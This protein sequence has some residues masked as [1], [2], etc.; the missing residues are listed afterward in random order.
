MYKKST[1]RVRGISSSRGQITVFMILGLLILF[2]F[3]FVFSLS[4]GIKKSQ[5]QDIQEKTLTKSFKKEALRI[6][7][8]DCLIDE[9]ETGLVII[10]KQGRLWSDQPGG[11]R[12][13]EEGLS[14]I[15]AGNDRVFYGIIRDPYLEY[16]NAYPCSNESSPDEFCQYSYPDTKV[17]FGSLELRSSTIQSDLRRYLLNRTVWCVSEFTRNNI[18]SSAVL[19][20]QEINLD[21]G[22]HDHGIDVKVNYP[23]KLSLGNEEFFHLSQFDFFYPTRFKALLDTAVSYPLRIDW[24]YVDFSYNKST[25]E[26]TSFA[27]GNEVDIQNGNCSPFKNYFF[28]QQALFSEQY[29]SLGVEMIRQPLPN[30]DDVFIFKSPSVLNSPELYTYQFARQNRPPALDYVH[31]LECPAAGYD[32]VVI[33]GDPEL[34][35]INF[36]LSASDPDEDKVSYNILSDDLGNSEGQDYVRTEVAGRKEPYTIR[37]YARDQHNVQDWQNVRVLV[38]RPLELDVSLF[39]PYKFRT[40]DGN[41]KDYSGADGI[42]PISG[43][44]LVSIEDPS[45]LKVVFP[46]TSYAPPSS[47]S[48]EI[49]LTYSNKNGTGTENFD[50]KIPEGL[51]IVGNQGCFSFPGGSSKSKDCTLTG[52][53]DDISAWSK[54]FTGV[55]NNFREVTEKGEL[56]LSF[57]AQYCARFTEVESE[58]I[59]VV[60]NECVPHRNPGHP[61][62]YPNHNLKYD[63]FNFNTLQGECV[64]DENGKCVEEEINPFEATHSCCIGVAENPNDWQIADADHPKPCFVNPEPG[65]YGQV[66]STKFSGTPYTSLKPGYVQEVQQ[67][68]CSG[69][70]GNT[71]DGAFKNKLM[72]GTLICGRPGQ[73]GCSDD[74]DLKCAGLFAFG[75]VGE[76]E[77]KGWCHGTFGCSDFCQKPVAYTGPSTQEKVFDINAIALQ[78]EALDESF[79]PFSCGCTAEGQLCDRNFD[80][81]F[82]GVCQADNSCLG[83]A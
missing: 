58:V 65:C 82:N 9:L 41:V 34:G 23:L 8:E 15:N 25:L 66:R 75:Y 50:Y 63:N 61:W 77:N 1:G 16:E 54:L 31:R 78:E 28:C 5:L 4:A 29:A 13:F 12:N 48:Q 40:S 2:V 22:I 59:K 73:T 19:E 70:R 51:Q 45:F 83:E 49:R 72:D 79:I 62:A 17:G 21:L 60:V 24:Q 47:Y 35:I 80:G 26:N 52:Y 64:A 56:N 10:G 71:C 43:T 76:E 36:T 32:Y 37:A 20:S 69:N 74:I 11:T 18:S 3:I 38:D 53:K 27:Y 44:Y 30:G 6:F 67:Q 81:K 55:F 46:E 68:F 57:N 39:M 14:G 33:K 42:F 7:V